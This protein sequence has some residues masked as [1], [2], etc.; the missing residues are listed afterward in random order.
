MELDGAVK[1]LRRLFGSESVFRLKSVRQ[2]EIESGRK[3]AGTVSTAQ[4]S[5]HV[6]GSCRVEARRD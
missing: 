2:L 5:S 1:R 3:G 4:K 6:S